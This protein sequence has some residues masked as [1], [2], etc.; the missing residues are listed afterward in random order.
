MP[1][2]TKSAAK[3]LETILKFIAADD[4]ETAQHIAK[5]IEEAINRLE[6]FPT[7]GREGRV[8]G[9]RELVL[10][11]IPYIVIY[12]LRKGFVSILRIVHCKM[13]WP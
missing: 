8:Q 11:R 5:Q 3:D 6:E 9:T 2:W 13:Q 4:R 1:R 12:R 7:M 10:P